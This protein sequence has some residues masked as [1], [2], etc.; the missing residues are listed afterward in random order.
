[1]GAIALKILVA[2]DE[3]EVLQYYKVLLEDLGYEV[4]ATKNGQECLEVYRNGAGSKRGFDLVILD[5]KIP[6]KTGMEVANEIAAM[7]PMQKLLMVTAYAGVLDLTQKPENMII[8]S[9]PFDPYE[10][11]STIRRLTN[12]VLS[13]S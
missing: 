8:M 6:R 5:H 4:V 11:I 12:K 7:A 3:P 1:M 9:K 13:L 10:L 2:E